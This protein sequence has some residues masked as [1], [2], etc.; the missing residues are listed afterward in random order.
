LDFDIL[1]IGAGVI[2][3]STAEIFSRNKYRVLVLE[4]E[5][6]IGTG[7]SSRN[8][9]VIHAGIYYPK[10]SL[11][12]ILCLRGKHLLYDWC[13]KKNVSY[14]KLGKYII[15]TNKEEFE[16]LE[17]IKDNALQAGLKELYF[18][19]ASEINQEEPDIFSIG[20][21]YSPTSGI[22]S[23]H[24]LMESFKQ[25]SEKNGADFLFHSKVKSIEKNSQSTG[26]LVEIIDSTNQV[27][28]IEVEI[29]INCAGLYADQ[30][31]KELGAYDNLYTQKF[32]KG[33]YFKIIGHKFHFKHLI[34]P[35]PLPKLHGL[36]VHVT[37]GLNYE[38]KFGPDVENLPEKVEDYSVD[39]NRKYDFYQAI[40]LYLPLIEPD[41]LTSE[42]SGIRPRL[43]AEREF[44]DFIINE[45]SE[46]GYP[47]LVNCTGMES[48]G[49]TAS[50]AIAEYIYNKL[51]NY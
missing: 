30:V 9:E 16:K 37:L 15:A 43:A 22:V 28:Q 32:V 35:V 24:E 19:N 27:F 14:K 42:M 45:E 51:L 36:G 41:D 6:R 17:K 39:E 5:N 10:D 38:V 23:A 26:Y 2:G 47:G 18:V 4:K 31:A 46:K 7:V 29:V 48:P 13:E 34:Y 25:I 1:I 50:L 44:N 3:L 21:I 12:S 49:L 33:N 11:K 40:K 8:S 20:G